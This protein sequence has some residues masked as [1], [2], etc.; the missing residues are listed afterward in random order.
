MT[1]EDPIYFDQAAALWD[2]YRWSSE[3]RSEVWIGIFKK[4]SRYPS[5]SIRMAMD[6]A[7]CFG[8]SESKWVTIDP[9]RFCIRFTPRI[10]GNAWSPSIVKRY[11]ELELEGM[12]Q[13]SGRT[14]WE[15]RD[16][17]ATE[18]LWQIETTLDFPAAYRKLLEEADGLPEFWKNSP[19]SYR[20]S[21]LKWIL[22]P[23]N[24]A[25]SLKRMEK[26]VQRYLDGDP[27]PAR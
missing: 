23:K 5:I 4:A 20:K 27:M 21:M 13:A 19:A 1:S 22:S 24:A 9:Q 10:L 16:M 18:R 8:W 12:I 25:L 3:G 7:L 14:A 15:A 11:L 17:A 2:W 6:A 26:F